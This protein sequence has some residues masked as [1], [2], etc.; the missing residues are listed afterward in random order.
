[1]LSWNWLYLHCFYEWKRLSKFFR[2]EKLHVYIVLR[3]QTWKIIIALFQTLVTTLIS[4]IQYRQQRVNRLPSWLLAISTSFW[5]SK[6]PKITSALRVTMAQHWWKTLCL[7]TSKNFSCM[8]AHF[9]IMFFITAYF[10]KHTHYHLSNIT[11]NFLKHT[12]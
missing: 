8:T 10:Y 7:H 11:N 3:K 1:M 12:V 9:S 5:R 2:A 4:T 6:K